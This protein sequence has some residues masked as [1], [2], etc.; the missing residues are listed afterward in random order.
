MHFVK[1]NVFRNM[2]GITCALCTKRDCRPAADTWKH[3]VYII[4][5]V[6]ASYV[7]KIYIVYTH[8]H[9]VRDKTNSAKL[10]DRPANFSC[11]S[12]HY[13]QSKDKIKKKVLFIV[14]QNNKI[15][16]NEYNEES[17]RL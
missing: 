5:S 16:R 1:L 14:D 3:E 17:I 11:I 7:Q 12:T 4:Y 8:T 2:L 9:S 10:Q 15:L 6:K 13:E